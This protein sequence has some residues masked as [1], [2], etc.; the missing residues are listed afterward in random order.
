MQVLPDE[1][2]VEQARAGQREALGRL[3]DRYQDRLFRYVRH[4]GFSEEDAADIVQD[5]FVRAYRH[6]RR[7]GDPT[8]FG[9]WIFKITRNLCR[10]AGA[11]ERRRE[12]V[13]LE[14]VTLIDADPGP[15]SR[16]KALAE[17]HFIRAAL[18][19]LPQEQQEALVLFYLMGH[20]VR[21]IADL[22]GAS[23]SAV[24]MRLKRARDALKV[25]LTP[26]VYEEV[27]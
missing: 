3:V 9:G 8:R 13:D 17:K 12:M 23:Q 7:C 14:S 1:V 15:E 5:A 25:R 6:L 21:E 24:K 4:L 19:E 16:M 22:T 10:T 11:K 20:T 18:E 27:A 26:L 2:L